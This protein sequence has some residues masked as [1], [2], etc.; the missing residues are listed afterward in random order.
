M[1]ECPNCGKAYN[2]PK[3]VFSACGYQIRPR[4]AAE[5]AKAFVSFVVDVDENGVVTRRKKR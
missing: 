4:T 5:L 3:R 1:I 2:N